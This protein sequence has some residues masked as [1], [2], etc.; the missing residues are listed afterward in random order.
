MTCFSLSNIH[1]EWWFKDSNI[2]TAFLM[3]VIWREIHWTITFSTHIKFHSRILCHK[4]VN[5]LIK[6]AFQRIWRSQICG[7]FKH[8]SGYWCICLSCY[9]NISIC[10]FIND[11]FLFIQLSLC[12][13]NTYV[14]VIFN[15]L[16]SLLDSLLRQKFNLVLFVWFLTF[17]T[18]KSV[19]DLQIMSYFSVDFQLFLLFLFALQK[20]SK[21]YFHL[22]YE[23]FNQKD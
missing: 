14:K 12:L 3:V 22:Q 8:H 1:I 9:Q 7:A 6:V 15:F 20:S 17:L 23:R 2:F 4:L 5:V 10:D 21:F 19:Y 18:F 13:I 11:K 16:I